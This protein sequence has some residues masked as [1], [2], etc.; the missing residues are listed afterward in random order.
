MGKIRKAAKKEAQ[1]DDLDEMER[2]LL[3][4]FL[5]E[6]INSFL[7]TEVRKV[8][9]EWEKNYSTSPM[10]LAYPGDPPKGAN[11]NQISKEGFKDFMTIG[12]HIQRDFLH[13]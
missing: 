8:V 13:F 11:L 1:E 4:K 9:K 5:H 10:L 6:S 3:Q 7:S 2:E 12:Y